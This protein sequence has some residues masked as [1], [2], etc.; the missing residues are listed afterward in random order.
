MFDTLTELDEAI[1]DIE[2]ISEIVSMFLNYSA[3]GMQ[4]LDNFR[5]G[6]WKIDTMIR[7]SAKKFERINEKLYEEYK[8]VAK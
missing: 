1:L 2:G 7:D 4:S 6:L 3:D 5:N 8:K